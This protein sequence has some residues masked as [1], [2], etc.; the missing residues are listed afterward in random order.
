MNISNK[1]LA[2]IFNQK[3]KPCR[4]C[5]SEVHKDDWYGSSGCSECAFMNDE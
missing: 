3:K 1:V 5:G 2:N 4:L